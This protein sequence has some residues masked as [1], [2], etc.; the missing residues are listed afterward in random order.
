[1]RKQ[2]MQ[3]IRHD[4]PDVMEGFF[5]VIVHEDLLEGIA[6]CGVLEKASSVT[7][8]QPRL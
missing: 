8:I 7:F 6:V 4:H 1:M 2:K 3:V 5:L